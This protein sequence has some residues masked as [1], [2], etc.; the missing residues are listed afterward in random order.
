MK[1]IARLTVLLGILAAVAAGSL[2]GASSRRGRRADRPARIHAHGQRVVVDVPPA[3]RPSR[4]SPSGGAVRYELQISQSPAFQE[5]GILYDGKSFLTPVAAPSSRFRGSPAIRT[6]CTPGFAPSSPRRYVAVERGLRLRRRPA[7]AADEP[8]SYAGLLR[9]SPVDGA[10]ALRSLAARRGQD[11]RGQHRTCSTSASSTAWQRGPATVRWRVRADADERARSDQRDAG[12]DARPWSPIYTVEQLGAYRPLRSQ[13]VG[14][15]SETFSDGSS[16]SS[17]HKLMPAF[18]WTGNEDARAERR[19]RSS[20]S[21]CSRTAAASTGS[22]PAHASRPGLRA[23]RRSEADRR[24]GRTH[25]RTATPLT[26]NEDNLRP[27]LRPR[28]CHGHQG[29]D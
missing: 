17:A 3:L 14:T 25:A 23:A 24:V 21:R 8:S 16:S 13:L 27:R 26:P 19:P 5:N 29:Q 15:V 11:R 28:R 22:G 9:W 4:G 2:A 12:H 6:R 1:R 18:V 10:T 20:A 7:R